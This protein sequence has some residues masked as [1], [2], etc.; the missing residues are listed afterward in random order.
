MTG[1]VFYTLTETCFRTFSV[2]AI[3]F[4]MVHVIQLNT[5]MGSERPVALG[6]L[7]VGNRPEPS[8]S[9]TRCL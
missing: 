4:V 8:R 9:G 7:P 1:E 3:V 6:P 5:A 2:G